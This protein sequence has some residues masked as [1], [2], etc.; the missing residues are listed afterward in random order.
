MKDKTSGISFRIRNN[1]HFDLIQYK[2]NQAKPIEELLSPKQKNTDVVNE[3][4]RYIQ[5]ITN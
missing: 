3:K 4:S 2:E 1:P 5:T